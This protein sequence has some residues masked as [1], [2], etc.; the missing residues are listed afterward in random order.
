MLQQPE[1]AVF[2][3]TSTLHIIVMQGRYPLHYSTTLHHPQFQ[4]P[5]IL[6]YWCGAPFGRRPLSVG[7]LSK[8]RRKFDTAGPK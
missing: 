2:E 8:R 3:R 4:P 5:A 6:R 7:V 1:L